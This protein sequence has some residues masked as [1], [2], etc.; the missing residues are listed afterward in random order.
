MS[1]SIRPSFVL[2]KEIIP[3]ALSMLSRKAWSSGIPRGVW[4]VQTLPRNSE[5]RPISCQNLPD[6]EN[7]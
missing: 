2:E 3:T 7:C 5:G 4:G 1:F 6:C